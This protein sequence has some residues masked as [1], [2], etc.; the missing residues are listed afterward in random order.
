MYSESRSFLFDV[1]IDLTQW[2]VWAL[3]LYYYSSFIIIPLLLFLLHYSSF[4]VIPNLLFLL[5]YYS[6]FI[7]IPNLLFL[8]YYYSSF[9]IPPLLLFFL[10]SSSSF[11]IPPLLLFLLYCYSSFIIPSLLLFLLCYYLVWAIVQWMTKRDGFLTENQIEND[12]FSIKIWWSIRVTASCHRLSRWQR[13]LM[14][15]SL[16]TRLMWQASCRTCLMLSALYIHAGD[17]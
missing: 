4:I 1:H 2:L 15:C 6:S 16:F 7:I 14:Q 9:I 12:G 3:L 13:W 10:Y 17:W 5:C 8:L 11:I